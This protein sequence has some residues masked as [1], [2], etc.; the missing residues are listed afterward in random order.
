MFSITYEHII[1]NLVEVTSENCSEKN[2][3]YKLYEQY[4]LKKTIFIHDNHQNTCRLQF[5]EKT[6]KRREIILKKM[7]LKY[8]SNHASFHMTINTSPHNI[9]QNHLIPESG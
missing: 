4:Y 5:H 6:Q 7:I 3:I 2:I 8:C 9:L 1:I